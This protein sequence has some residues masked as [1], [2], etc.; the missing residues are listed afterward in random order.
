MR[1]GDTLWGIASRYLRSP[2]R[3]PD[4]W[5]LNSKIQNPDLIY[6][7]DVI[8][9]GY[10][11]GR[12]EL[13][14]ERGTS[15][16]AST[17]RRRLHALLAQSHVQPAL[18]VV[19]LR[20]KMIVRPLGRAIAVIPYADIAPFFQRTEAI[21]ADAYRHLPYILRSVR[22]MPYDAS[23]ERIYV[24]GLT[25]TTRRHYA[26]VHVFH[27]IRDPSTDD[28]LGYEVEQVGR[29]RLI[30]NGNPALF[31]LTRSHREIS[32]G[33]RLIPIS[34]ANIRRNIHPTLPSKIIQ[35]QIIDVVPRSPDISQYAIVIINRGRIAGLKSGNVLD[36]FRPGESLEDPMAFGSESGDVHIR[37]IKV[38]TAL[39]F[40]TYPR[41]S[42]ALVMTEHWQVHVLAPVASPQI[43]PRNVKFIKVARPW[44]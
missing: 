39:V 29:A 41:F 40:K 32:Q 27:A 12:R 18:P 26:V 8:L 37:P 16:V 31:E 28:R 3:W 4:I 38:G 30:R 11:R 20:P 21:G 34:Q 33:D 19:T 10:E 22:R 42:Y 25:T 17:S 14:I 2:W 9:L 1:S 43:N 5:Y 6:P 13:T 24:R 15:I 23:P 36:I 35:G 44:D 7:G